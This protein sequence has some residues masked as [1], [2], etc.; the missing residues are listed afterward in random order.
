MKAP[1]T[2]E[3]ATPPIRRHSGCAEALS[4]ISFYENH[5][6]WPRDRQQLVEVLRVL[7][8]IHGPHPKKAFANAVTWRDPTIFAPINLFALV[9][10]KGNWSLGSTTSRCPTIFQIPLSSKSLVVSIFPKTSSRV[11]YSEFLVENK[12][13][14]AL[15][16][17]F[18]SYDRTWPI[19]DAPSASPIANKSPAFQVCSLKFATG[20]SFADGSGRQW[21]GSSMVRVVNG[22]TFP[23]VPF[24][25]H[26]VPFVCQVSP[27]FWRPPCVR[28]MSSSSTSSCF[29]GGAVPRI[30]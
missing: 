7:V 23:S 18:G 2:T 17:A 16:I 29:P 22:S 20:L 19:A 4:L 24:F 9:D 10:S 12:Q 8:K 3:H 1:C 14:L 5:V 21:F 26:L 27:S 28:I 11:G 25:A 15:F 6:H 30:S 13:M